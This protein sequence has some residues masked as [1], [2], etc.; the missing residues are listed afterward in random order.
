[1]NNMSTSLVVINRAAVEF[2]YR[3]AVW[4]FLFDMEC[5]ESGCA[6]ETNFNP[7]VMNLY[8]NEALALL[9]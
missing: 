4:I 5:I 2:K 8:I 6:E 3:F 7:Y 9:H 1:M